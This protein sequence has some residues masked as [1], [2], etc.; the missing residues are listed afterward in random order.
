MGRTR[1]ETSKTTQNKKKIVEVSATDCIYFLS[2]ADG[3][4]IRS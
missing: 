1:E 4:K 3:I 2:H